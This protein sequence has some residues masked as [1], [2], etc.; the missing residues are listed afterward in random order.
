MK[1]DHEN[2]IFRI[3]QTPINHMMLYI[4]EVSSR[5]F[6]I[7]DILRKQIGLVTVFKEILHLPQTPITNIPA[8]KDS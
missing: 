3:L 4:T 1:S 7:Q 5:V 8:D 6:K 2:L